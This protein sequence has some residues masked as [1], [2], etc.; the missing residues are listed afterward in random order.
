[1]LSMLLDSWKERNDTL[2]FTNEY[3]ERTLMLREAL[4]DGT[5]MI[6]IESVIAAAAP[7]PSSTHFRPQSRHV[8]QRQDCPHHSMFRINYSSS[9]VIS[10]FLCS[11]LVLSK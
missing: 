11:S 10:I 4:G 2:P 5:R 1:M 6:W 9:I 8:I 7:V 3:R